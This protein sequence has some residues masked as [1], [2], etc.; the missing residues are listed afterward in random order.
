MVNQALTE[1]CGLCWR[2][3]ALPWTHR[4]VGR[5]NFYP[6]SQRAEKMMTKTIRTGIAVAALLIA[7]IAAQAADFPQP[8][9]KAPAYSAPGFS[10][11][12]FYVG[13]N[14]GYG[15]GNASFSD[16]AMPTLAHRSGAGWRVAPLDTIIRPGRGS[17]ASRAT[18]T[19]APSRE[20]PPFAA[21]QGARLETPG[22]PPDAA[23]SAM[24][25]IAGFRSSLAAPPTA[26]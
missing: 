16:P 25:G 7:P 13:L 1:I 12:G 22:S 19:S 18:L 20:P 8:R 6:T 5:C 3:N 23:A 26:T 14:A 2:S 11:T 24:P 9:Y 4:H 21:R 15:W 10:W 17:G